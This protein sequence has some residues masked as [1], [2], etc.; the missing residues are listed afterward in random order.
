MYLLYNNCE[1]IKNCRSCRDVTSWFEHAAQFIVPA[2]NAIFATPNIK[3]KTWVI[4]TR[5]QHEIAYNKL[6][7]FPAVN[8]TA[9]K[10]F[11]SF[12]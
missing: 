11:L 1:V 9:R 12:S 6:L 3:G 10:R 2:S 7:F 8:S 5:E 4:M